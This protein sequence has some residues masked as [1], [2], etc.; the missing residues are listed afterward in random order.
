MT[1]CA[2]CGEELTSDRQSCES[3]G[4]FVFTKEII[5]DYLVKSMERM[6][7]YLGIVEILLGIVLA[8]YIR[9]AVPY[10]YFDPVGYLLGIGL[11]FG[12]GLFTI[13]VRKRASEWRRQ[14]IIN[15]FF[16]P[17]QGLSFS[18]KDVYCYS[19]GSI[20]RDNFQVCIKC[21]EPLLTEGII[22]KRTNYQ[23]IKPFPILGVISIIGGTFFGFLIAQSNRGIYGVVVL[24]VC[25]YLI[26]SGLFLVTM[27]NKV[28]VW[29]ARRFLYG[30]RRWQA[31][32]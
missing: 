18:D 23:C 17:I 19:C 8:I 29:G 10:K 5:T 28:S 9:T 12:F 22:F 15:M 20:N 26:I 32:Q 3:C 4:K 16:S 31:A 27:P 14:I 11:V 25:L 1:F 21:G 13:L 24:I 7:L 6:L 30:L 2:E